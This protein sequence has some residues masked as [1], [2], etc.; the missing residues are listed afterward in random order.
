VPLILQRAKKLVNKNFMEIM[1]D[2]APEAVSKVQMVTGETE[3]TNQEI[4]T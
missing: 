3:T 2:L 1:N 4:K